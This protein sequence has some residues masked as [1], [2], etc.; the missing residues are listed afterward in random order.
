MEQDI[1]AEK[2]EQWKR[3]Q[4]GYHLQKHEYYM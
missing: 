2:M 3:E 4:E 1:V